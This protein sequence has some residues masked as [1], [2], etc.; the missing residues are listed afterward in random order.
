MLRELRERGCLTFKAGYVAFGD[1][2][3]LSELAEYDP[4][5]LGLREAG[6]AGLAIL[7]A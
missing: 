4:G 2:E 7:G 1:I 6:P 3:S 5:Y